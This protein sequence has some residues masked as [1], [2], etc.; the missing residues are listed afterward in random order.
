MPAWNDQ[1]PNLWGR[2]LDQVSIPN[3]PDFQENWGLWVA[4][5][6]DLRAELEHVNENDQH[7]ENGLLAIWAGWNVHVDICQ[8]SGFYSE[9]AYTSPL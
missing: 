8:K 9:C 2:T 6:I 7:F 3:N 4:Y 5:Y 1:I